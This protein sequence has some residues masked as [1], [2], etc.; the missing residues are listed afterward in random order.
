MAAIETEES[1]TAE[2]DQWCEEK[3]FEPISAD[4]LLYELAADHPHHD[5][6]SDWLLDFIE[7]WERM[8]EAKHDLRA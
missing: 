7:R 3:G 8:E 5:E 4:E 2:F 6:Y 1:L